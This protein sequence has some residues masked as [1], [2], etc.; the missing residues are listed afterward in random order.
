MNLFAN[1]IITQ[2]CD[3][4]GV[5]RDA[6]FSRR[7]GDGLIAIRIV[8]IERIWREF[9]L[10]PSA[11]GRLL[12]RDHSTICHHLRAIKKQNTSPCPSPTSKAKTAAAGFRHPDTRPGRRHPILTASFREAA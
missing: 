2:E 5:S 8:I 4:H 12:N 7:R 10:G 3:K 6:V 1:D 11:I 9:N